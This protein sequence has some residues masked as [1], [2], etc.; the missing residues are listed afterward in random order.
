MKN[1]VYWIAIQ[2]VFGYGSN[3][4][5]NIL[6]NFDDVS[7]L[8]DK[9]LKRE[10]V[11]FIPDKYFKKLKSYNM[12]KAK[13]I[14][15]YC[16]RKN[17]E[18]ITLDD[19]KYPLVL[20]RIKNPPAVLY[21]RGEF[22]NFDEEVVIG[23]I[24]TRKCAMNSMI[25]ASTLAYRIAQSGAIVLSGGADGIDTKCTQ[26]A[27]FAKQPSVLIRPCGLDYGYL[28]SLYDIRKSVEKCG[29]VISEVQP[30]GKIER[31]AFQ[32]RNRLMAAL[33]IG[34]VVIE[35]PEITGVSITVGYALEYGKDIF[36][37]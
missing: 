37:V 14:I 24:G 4:V 17:I 23:M 16:D 30:L 8:F 3:I 18:I 1:A 26:G 34:V 13:E 25:V 6:E 20:K 21:S 29:A 22:P 9:N 12:K 35:A 11:I 7:L 31:N 27:L 28:K 19:E 36:K 5:G 32:I 33:S 2:S 10:D 15:E